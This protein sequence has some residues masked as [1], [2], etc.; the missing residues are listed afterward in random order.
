MQH[1]DD[2]TAY[3][4]YYL[5]R[6]SYTIAATRLYLEQ[7]KSIQIPVVCAT[8][9]KMA[10]NRNVARAIVYGPKR[11]GGMSLCHLHNLRGIH[12]LPYFSVHIAK[13]DGVGK[14]TRICIE[15][16]QLEVGTFE[17]FL[18]TRHSI[19]GPS[20]LTASW[21]L[22]IWYFL[23]L[24]KVTINITNSWIPSPQ[25]QD[26]QALMSLSILHTGRKGELHQINRCQIFLRVV[27]V[28]DITDFDSNRI[29]Q[30]SYDGF[31]SVDL[32]TI[33][34]PYQQRPTVDISPSSKPDWALSALNYGLTPTC[35]LSQLR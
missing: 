18:F 16:T 5:A 8:L 27:S 29:N 3:N 17:P 7:C 15:A 23:E 11:L 20:T 6:I 30:T 24:F 13:K 2:S 28:S 25:S 9:N 33:R 19:H 34:W 4:C 31:R 32:T 22:E 14:L 1:Y 10:I 26:D 21:V 35:N 12:R